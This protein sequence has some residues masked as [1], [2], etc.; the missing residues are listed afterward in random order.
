[1]IY[2]IY[3]YLS[4]SCFDSC[5]IFFRFITVK[6]YIINPQ[7]SIQYALGQ[8]YTIVNLF[9][10]FD[11][12]IFVECCSATGAPVGKPFVFFKFFYWCSFP[13]SGIN[14]FPIYCVIQ[15]FFELF[16]RPR[17][18][19]FTNLNFIPVQFVSSTFYLYR[20]SSI[21][22][23][24][25]SVFLCQHLFASLYPSNISINLLNMKLIFLLLQSAFTCPS[26]WQ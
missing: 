14:K 12:C 24:I 3:L 4:R 1:M 17:S 26:I 21:L 13:Q 20:D 25:D 7:W 5:I 10:M 15:E 23:F 2:F 19:I 11:V 22:F 18:C 8:G 16:W 6:E 9:Y